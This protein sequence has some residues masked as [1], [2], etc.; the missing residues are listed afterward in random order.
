LLGILLRLLMAILSPIL[1]SGLMHIVTDGWN[2]LFGIINPAFPAIA[3]VAILT[4]LVWAVI[5]R[6][7]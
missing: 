7:R 4:A 5:G 6:R 3:A 2:L 1:P